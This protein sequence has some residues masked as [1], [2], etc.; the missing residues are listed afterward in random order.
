VLAEQQKKL[1]EAME[2]QQ[3]E[4]RRRL[5]GDAAPAPGAPAP[6]TPPKP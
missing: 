2:K 6:A 5:G 1:Q 3:E 4:L